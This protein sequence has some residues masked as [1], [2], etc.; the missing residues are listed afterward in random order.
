MDYSPSCQA[1][2][3]AAILTGALFIAV[4]GCIAN[5]SDFFSK[6]IR[7]LRKDPLVRVL[8]VIGLFSVGPITSRSKNGVPDRSVQA[9]QISETAPPF[10]CHEAR[11]NG[12]AMVAPS[13]NAIVSQACLLHGAS[14]AGEWIESEAS[15]FR[16]GTNDI[17]RLYASPGCLSFGTKRHPYLGDALPNGTPAESLVALRM[18]LGIVPEANWHVLEGTGVVSRFW[19]DSLP[20]G[21]RVFTWEN[22]L[23]DRLS[24]RPATIQV[25]LRRSGD[26]VYRYDFSQAAPTNAFL[27]GAQKAA[28]AVEALRVGNAETNSA[29]VYRLAGDTA[30]NGVPIAELF[31]AAPLLELRWKNVA[32]LGDLSG[33]TDDDGLTD[34]DEVFLYGTDPNHADT[35]GDGASDFLELA[36]GDD[37]LN[38]DENGDGIPDGVSAT[39]W[40]A[41]PLWATNSV[42]GGNVTI[43]LNE[44]I[45]SGA[46]ATL[47]LGSLSIPLRNA[48]SMDFHIPVGE[49]IQGR[50]FS[51]GVDVVNLSISPIDEPESPVLLRG[52]G[53]LGVPRLR[54]DPKGVLDGNSS[55]GTFRIAVP[56][57]WICNLDGTRAVS[58]CVHDSEGVREYMVHFSPSD[59][60]LS[61]DD[62]R[63]EGFERVGDN[64]L[65]LSV[66]DEAYDEVMGRVSLW[67]YMDYGIVEDTVFLWRCSMP[68]DEPYPAALVVD[69]GVAATNAFKALLPR[70]STNPPGRP[71]IPCRLRVTGWTEHAPTFHISGPKLK[72]G[73]NAQDSITATLSGTNVYNF[74]ISGET[75]SETMNDALIY[76][77]RDGPTGPI[78]ATGAVTVVWV[79]PITMRNGQGDTFSTDNISS[80]K[81][82]PP[83]LGSQKYTMVDGNLGVGNIVEIRGLVHPL[84]F[85]ESLLFARDCIY[86]WLAADGA[87]YTLSISI[88]KRNCPRVLGT[89]NDTPPL[90]C[91]SSRASASGFIY[92]YDN[93][94]MPFFHATNQIPGLVL[95]QRMNFLQYATCK[96]IR[97]SDDFA[98]Y[99][100]LTFKNGND[101]GSGVPDIWSRDFHDPDNSSGPGFTRIGKD[102]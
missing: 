37:P 3:L 21:G 74:V 59:W 98:W 92:D 30:T 6:T 19:H 18:P 100:R 61:L 47:V 80:Q 57:V 67:K 58:E 28:A 11:T 85:S 62:V 31:A 51:R 13:T 42:D 77:R 65:R 25:E 45:P 78:C 41:N 5:G 54:D 60:G 34:W 97:C 99:S 91:Q 17:Q 63:L 89:G 27:V 22:V 33:D 44:P 81:P 43:A 32:G 83:L 86:E 82:V 9:T 1:I 72:F 88:N 40:A 24:D 75:A 48:V 35:D 8:L 46:T 2:S 52:G 50:L 20:G 36:W 39:D 84:N 95:Y 71:T 94:G 7:W 69:V 26:F 93:P 55:E 66:G 68:A 53:S 87:G 101:D 96:G 76:V 64:R 14:E 56:E 102:E 90:V 16:W 12:V 23:L 70:H 49:T 4:L 73:P 79:D 38:A 15:F 29:T 10:A